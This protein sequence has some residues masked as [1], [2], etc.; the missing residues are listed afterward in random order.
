MTRPY[1]AALSL[2]ALAAVPV[3]CA[4]P[5]GAFPSLEHRPAEGRGFA[6]PAAPPA[7]PT[8]ADP[9]LDARVRTIGGALDASARAFDAA[10]VRAR[11][12][13][14]RARGARAGSEAWVVAQSALAE[15]DSIR[16]D[17]SAAATDA[18]EAALARAAGAAGPYPALETL[19]ARAAAE[20]ERQERATAELSAP[21]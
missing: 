13:A 7:A 3:G 15:L 21:R 8:A 19:R 12:A 6:E 10:A 2:M 16:A 1:R 9:A 5:E 14:G 20:V 18:D 4:R 17:A 11:A